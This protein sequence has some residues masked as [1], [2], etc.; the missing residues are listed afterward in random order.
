VTG[1]LT[2]LG[3]F[4]LVR[5]LES[6]WA[7]R[8]R[9][10]VPGAG[11]PHRAAIA[12]QPGPAALVGQDETGPGRSAS[13]TKTGGALTRMLGDVTEQA[14]TASAARCRDT[15]TLAAERAAAASGVQIRGLTEIP[16]LQ[17]VFE[18]Y[19]RIWHPDPTNPPITTE[20]LR[21]LS[22]A[23]NYVA[24]AYR[25]GEMVGACVGFY[26][27][28]AGQAMHSHVAG[29]VASMR[30]RNVGFALKVHQRA[31]ALDRG[32]SAITWTFDPLVCRN[33]YFNLAKL[34]ARPRSYLPDFYGK[35]NDEINGDDD[36]D[37]L[38]V[39]W[40]LADPAVE[41]ACAGRHILADAAALRAGGVTVALD[42]DDGGMPVVAGPR[43][44][45][46]DTLLVRVPPDIE[47]MRLDAGPHARAWRAALR[48][49]LGA[50]LAAG[51][52]VTGFDRAGWYVV[53]K[54]R[55]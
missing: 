35:M 34:A 7:W 3:E 11:R 9:G 51:A 31:W 16:D 33:A 47:A 4:R 40:R 46:G 13:H 21:A 50:L 52:E 30:G 24:G 42:A 49:V 55:P 18:L 1:H 36:S 25:D 48:Q 53:R 41:R 19:G 39:E 37:R 6:A 44:P 14:T 17:Q 10:P 22:H 54:P 23:G 38:L 29:V 2:S 26:A 20:F 12:S 43:G 27:E 32:I 15:A 28:P 45:E 5:R 8:P